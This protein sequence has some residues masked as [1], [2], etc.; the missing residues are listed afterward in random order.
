MFL[1]YSARRWAYTAHADI[2]NQPRPLDPPPPP[3]QTTTA[4]NTHITRHTYREK[5]FK[6]VPR[7]S[8]M[9]SLTN[10]IDGDEQPHK[11][12]RWSMPFPLN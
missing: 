4:N 8:D 9:E 6:L 2:S 1:Y 5:Y 10:V 12:G 11:R 3:P 7:D